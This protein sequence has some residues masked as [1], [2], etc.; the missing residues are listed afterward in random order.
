MNDRRS[1][2]NKKSN[3]RIRN[4][5][6]TFQSKLSSRQSPERQGRPI[7]NHNSN[8]SSYGTNGNPDSSSIQSYSKK[9]TSVDRHHFRVNKSPYP[10]SNDS[11]YSLPHSVKKYNGNPG[12]H[13]TTSQSK[14][15]NISKNDI[16]DNTSTEFVIEEVDVNMHTSENTSEA[17]DLPYV[18]TRDTLN[19]YPSPYK[20]KL[21]K[22]DD[23][24]SDD[25]RIEFFS[26]HDDD[27]DDDNNDGSSYPLKENSF[28]KNSHNKYTSQPYTQSN[29]KDNISTT[30]LKLSDRRSQTPNPPYLSSTFEYDKPSSRNQ[31]TS[32]VN[33]T[34]S[35]S[36]ENL[37][38][39]SVKD[40]NNWSSASQTSA[41]YTNEYDK[42]KSMKRIEKEKNSS[43]STYENQTSFQT[44]NADWGYSSAWSDESENDSAH[45]EKA[46]MAQHDDSGWRIY[47]PPILDIR[48][49]RQK[50]SQQ[51]ISKSSP[52]TLLSNPIVNHPN[53]SNS[54]NK[55]KSNASSTSRAHSPSTYKSWDN[56]K[57]NSGRRSP[58]LNG[59]SMS[60]PRHKSSDESLGK[61]FANLRANRGHSR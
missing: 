48:A 2:R 7:H 61:A 14:N 21:A 41:K 54:T 15:W 47:D 56:G 18:D 3:E 16:T 8:N 27:G 45:K 38:S 31:S 9:S 5:G 59:C 50:P 57:Q 22:K 39:S 25:G 12:K 46:T 52:P 55:S 49:S 24:Q 53:L 4:Q 28:S 23:P 33:S 20:D 42:K 17:D 1:S 43:T 26:D 58:S 13:Q 19:N 30:T 29:S 60:D 40:H 37:S 34:Y 32:S 36:P 11:Y 6:E 35:N 10:T 51:N 44:G